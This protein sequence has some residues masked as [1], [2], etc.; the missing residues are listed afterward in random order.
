MGYA[1]CR[2]GKKRLVFLPLYLQSN[3]QVYDRPS[4][5]KHLFD[6]F[7][8]ATGSALANKWFFK[9]YVFASTPGGRVTA[10]ALIFM[11]P[12][13]GRLSQAPPNKNRCFLQLLVSFSGNPEWTGNTKI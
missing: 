7:R 9:V 13:C 11:L 8:L 3:Y 6:R 10:T 4:K 5:G 1:G 2:Q 12:S